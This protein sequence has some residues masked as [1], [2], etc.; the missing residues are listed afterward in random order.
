MAVIFTL[1]AA[2]A[3]ASTRDRAA[4]GKGG[5]PN[6]R[7]SRPTMR[8]STRTYRAGPPVRC[9]AGRPVMAQNFAGNVDAANSAADQIARM[10]FKLRA[11]VVKVSCRVRPERIMMPRRTS[12][13]P[14]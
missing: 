6:S 13:S 12:G 7:L 4:S 10:F 1:P 2:S 9:D 8:P 3:F 11:I 14:R 5:S